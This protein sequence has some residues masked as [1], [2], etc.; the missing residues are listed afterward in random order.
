M[1]G[2]DRIVDIIKNAI[3]KETEAFNYYHRASL[4]AGTVETESLLI[5]LAEEE[6][7][8]RIYLLQELERLESLLDKAIPE[9]S[10]ADA[11]VR[12][13]LPP[14]VSF[15]RMKTIRHIEIAAVCLPLELLGGDYIESFVIDKET[16]SHRLG[17]LLY[18]VMGHGLNATRLKA[19]AK[20]AIGNIRETWT[21]GRLSNFTDLNSTKQLMKELN[22]MLIQD[23]IM[24]NRFITA[25]YGVLDPAKRKLIYTS[26]GHE[27]PILI[28]GFG[29][30]IHLDNTQ[31]LIGAER[32]VVY[33]EIEVPIGPDDV[34]VFFSDGITEAANRHGEMFGRDRIRNVAREKRNQSAQ[35]IMGSIFSELRTFLDTEP[36]TDELLLCVVKIRIP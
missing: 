11:D 13:V 15:K 33:Q 31:L 10:V 29:E 19:E 6:R 30:Y 1:S 24:Y 25:F 3:R 28:N 17:L 32:N 5:Q 21:R 4:K 18:D 22:R 2:I 12:F 27:P 16:G 23:C 7:K 14:A 26:A 9:S 8:H 34:L 35:E 20:K 36:V